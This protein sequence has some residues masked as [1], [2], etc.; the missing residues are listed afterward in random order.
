MIAAGGVVLVYCLR[1]DYQRVTN[2]K[3]GDV[4]G[5]KVVKT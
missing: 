1:E 3:M 4:L 2:E 5:Q